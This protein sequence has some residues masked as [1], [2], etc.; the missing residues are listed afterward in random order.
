MNTTSLKLSPILDRKLVALAKREGVS[1]S[2]LLRRALMEYIERKT[3]KPAVSFYDVASDVI[4]SIDSGL[5]DLS[6][7]PKYMEGFG[8]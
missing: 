6:T 1:K 4:G 7:N 8:K 3:G 2:E 5:G